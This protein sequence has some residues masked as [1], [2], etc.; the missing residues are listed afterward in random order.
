MNHIHERF[1]R[2]QLKVS[3]SGHFCV[4]DD[5][6]SSMQ[7]ADGVIVAVGTPTKNGN[8]DLSYVLAACTQIGAAISNI[9]VLS[10]LLL[11]VQSCQAQQTP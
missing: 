1:L 8:I 7:N 3:N 4:S 5:L 11:K 10:Q 9:I 6:F 2:D